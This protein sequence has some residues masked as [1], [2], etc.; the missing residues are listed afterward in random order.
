MRLQKGVI[1]FWTP[2]MRKSTLFTLWISPN[3]VKGALDKFSL[4][5][6]L[7]KKKTEKN[8]TIRMYT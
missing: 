5:P 3:A 7:K 8:C 2:C 6:D 4:I 1:T